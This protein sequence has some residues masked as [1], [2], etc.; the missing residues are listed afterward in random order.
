MAQN[1][2]ADIVLDSLA[3]S[4]PV[5]AEAAGLLAQTSLIKGGLPTTD[6]GG[7]G[8]ARQDNILGASKITDHVNIVSNASP[9]VALAAPDFAVATA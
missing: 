5:L 8:R 1:E 2:S 6:A 4:S 3:Q 9:D 7:G